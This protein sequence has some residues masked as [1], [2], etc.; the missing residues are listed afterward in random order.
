MNIIESSTALV[1]NESR[2]RKPRLAE[3]LSKEEKEVNPVAS[4]DEASEAKMAL[5]EFIAQYLLG[6]DIGVTLMVIAEFLKEN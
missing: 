3:P 1:T 2:S 4:L 5:Q 6:L